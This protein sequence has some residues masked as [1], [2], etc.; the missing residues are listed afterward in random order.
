MQG[1]RYAQCD[2]DVLFAHELERY[3]KMTLKNDLTLYGVVIKLDTHY[4]VSP[5]RMTMDT[6]RTQLRMPGSLHQ[7]LTQR[8]RGK[9][10]SMN[11][12]INR[13]L[14]AER[15]REEEKER[16]YTANA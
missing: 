15:R 2:S 6:V 1:L 13:I 7:W 3:T 12:E 10:R 4:L 14:K 8:A 5:L 9:D 16:Q 11:A